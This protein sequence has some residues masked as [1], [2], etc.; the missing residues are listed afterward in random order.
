MIGFIIGVVVVGIITGV[1][2]ILRGIQLSHFGSKYGKEALVA[3]LDKI[4][5]EIAALEPHHKERMQQLESEA[6]SLEAKLADLDERW[7]KAG[8]ATEIESAYGKAILGWGNIETWL[9]NNG[10]INGREGLPGQAPT[11]QK[12]S[13]SNLPSDMK[14]Q[15]QQLWGSRNAY[16][17]RAGDAKRDANLVADALH[18]AQKCDRVLHDLEQWSRENGNNSK[19]T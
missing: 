11:K 14:F 19:T 9:R 10:I 16:V 13:D 2:C 3:Q 18:Y 17:H 7:A 6:K 4:K 12:I 5:A 8:Q 1:V 15:L